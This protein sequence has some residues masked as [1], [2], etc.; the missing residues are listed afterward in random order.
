[1]TKILPSTWLSKKKKPVSKEGEGEK[2]QE[3]KKERRE[4]RGD[5]RQ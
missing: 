1:M 4:K 5:E 3:E 2:K